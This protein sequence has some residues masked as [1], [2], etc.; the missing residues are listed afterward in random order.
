MKRN[1]CMMEL[2]NTFPKLELGGTGE[3]IFNTFIFVQF[4]YL[5]IIILHSVKDFFFIPL[6]MLLFFLMLFLF[7]CQLSELISKHLWEK[8]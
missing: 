1:T 7:R 2:E 5:I 4:I 3:L 8:T 6:K